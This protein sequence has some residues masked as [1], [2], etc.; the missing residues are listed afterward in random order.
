MMQLLDFPHHVSRASSS[1]GQRQCPPCCATFL[2][3]TLL[4]A[5]S[6]SSTMARQLACLHTQQQQQLVHLRVDAAPLLVQQ[7]AQPTAQP[8]STP[9]VLRQQLLQPQPL[10]AEVQA[11]AKTTSPKVPQWTQL[12]AV[13]STNPSSK[14]AQSNGPLM[15]AA[16]AASWSPISKVRLM[17]RALHFGPCCVPYCA[18][19]LLSHG[20]FSP[21]LCCIVLQCAA[22]CRT[23]L[24]CAILHCA[25]LHCAARRCTA[26]LC[27]ASHCGALTRTAQH[28]IAS[29]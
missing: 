17:W 15:K 26:P 5:A 27:T 2:L 7:Q 3:V 6:P 22:M 23:S 19:G 1:H 12:A 10:H 4:I 13:S 8:S 11:S 16:L 18:C 29:I 20:S 28:S 24:R 9:R 14:I 25:A 21:A